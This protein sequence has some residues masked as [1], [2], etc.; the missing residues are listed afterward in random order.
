MVAP[1]W[2]TIGDAFKKIRSIRGLDQAAFGRRYNFSRTLVSEIERGARDNYEPETIHVIEAILGWV[3]GSVD[4][5]KIGGHPTL[6]ADPAMAELRIF[7]RRLAPQ[8]QLA[9]ADLVRELAL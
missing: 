3:S 7:W 1:G 5:V 6:E 4:A 9:I 2:T 8:A